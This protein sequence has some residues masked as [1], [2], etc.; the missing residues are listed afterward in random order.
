MRMVHDEIESKTD[1]SVQFANNVLSQ[2]WHVIIN[3]GKFQ[4]LL[5][6]NRGMIQDIS[7][8]F[9]QGSLLI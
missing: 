2:E 6:I 3:C 9:K 7:K 8:A 1:Y 4:Q 5:V